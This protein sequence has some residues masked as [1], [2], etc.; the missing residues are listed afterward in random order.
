MSRQTIV[1]VALAAVLVGAF[2]FS[3]LEKKDEYKLWKHKFG[4]EY[5]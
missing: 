5:S 1:L 3:T 2:Y 4:I